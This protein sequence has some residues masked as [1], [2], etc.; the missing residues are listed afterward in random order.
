MD[1]EERKSALRPGRRQWRGDLAERGRGLVDAGFLMTLWRIGK[2][3][4]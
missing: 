1:S 3:L 4:A 2:Q